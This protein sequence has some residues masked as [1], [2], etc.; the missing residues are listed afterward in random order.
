[1]LIEPKNTQEKQQCIKN[2]ETPTAQTIMTEEIKFG[3]HFIWVNVK[4]AGL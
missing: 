3:Y 1:L 4:L 2:I